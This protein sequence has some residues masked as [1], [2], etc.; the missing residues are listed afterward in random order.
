MQ[1]DAEHQQ[2]DPEL[3]E[4]GCKRLIGD[5]ARRERAYRNTG[6]QISNQWRYAEPLRKCSKYEG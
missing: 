4:L 2:D 3:R 6:E 1:A 5:E